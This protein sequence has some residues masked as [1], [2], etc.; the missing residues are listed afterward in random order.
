[1]KRVLSSIGVLLAILACNSVVYADE[2]DIDADDGFV[3]KN[4][5]VNESFIRS[6]ARNRVHG[7]SPDAVF[8]EIDGID[9]FK[10]ELKSGNLERE[11]RDG[12]GITKQYI[13]KDIKNVT[14]DDKDLRDME[15]DMLD[16]GTQIR[17]ENQQVVQVL[18]ISDSDIRLETSQ[19]NAGIRSEVDDLSGI[20]NKTTIK[21]SV[22][23]GMDVDKNEIENSISQEVDIDR[24]AIE[25]S[26]DVDR[27]SI[28]N[29]V[30]QGVNINRGEMENSISQGIN[31]NQGAIR[32][33]VTQGMQ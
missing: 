18:N 17:S 31:V 2:A 11:I 4:N 6:I 16:L 29:S 1:M 14:L 33:S 24:S 19:I 26:V 30:S 21:N 28:E 25:N 32:N 9:E 8:V 15:Q 27:G 22:L 5:T 23:Q 20:V 3:Q 7:G 13:Y 12:N 10:D